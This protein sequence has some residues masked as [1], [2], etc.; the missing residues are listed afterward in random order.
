MKLT[1]NLK[2]K[3]S[4][5]FFTVFYLKEKNEELLKIENGFKMYFES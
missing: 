5:L 1:W 3:M 2:L 4:V